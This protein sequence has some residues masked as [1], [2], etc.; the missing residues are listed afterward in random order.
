MAGNGVHRIELSE[1]FGAARGGEICHRNYVS[2]VLLGFC[3]RFVGRW[4]EAL[5]RLRL[6][7]E[8]VG[9]KVSSVQEGLCFYPTGFYD[10]RE[11]FPSLLVRI[12]EVIWL[13]FLIFKN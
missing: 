13:E 8:V 3:S 10:Q 4:T 2:L 11:F 1:N 6:R 5:R 7:E 9:E 12:V